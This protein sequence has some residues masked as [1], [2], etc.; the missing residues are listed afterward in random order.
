MI[1][2]CQKQ[3]KDAQ[4]ALLHKYQNKFLGICLRYVDN[5]E[6][7]EEI[8]MDSFMTIFQKI[9]LYK[10][11][12]FE[13]WMKT[14]V[15]HKAIDYYRKHKN[16]PIISDIETEEWRS[17]K[18]HQNNN[19]EVQDLLQLLKTLP[20][21]YRLVFNLFAIEG[22]GHKE[23]AVKLDISENTSKSQYR[24]AKMKLQEILVKEGYHG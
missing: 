17:P 12:S 9:K 15:I 2:A 20:L 22:F 6:I 4:K 19:L 8:L 18:K 13:G 11:N 3:C 16:D 14:I 7:A 5:Q 10:E 24:K 1:E 21:G 23:I